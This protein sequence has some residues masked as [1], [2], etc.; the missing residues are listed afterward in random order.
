MPVLLKAINSVGD[1]SIFGIRVLRA[2]FRRPVEIGQIV[3]HMYE[4]G[5]RSLPLVGAAG[6]AVGAVMSMHTRASLERFGA[7]AMIP[8]GL[9]AAL[10][11]ETGPLVTALLFS[12]RVGAGIGAELGAMRVS[13]QID[14]LETLAVDSFKYLVVTR[15]LACIAVMPLL[16]VAANFA[17]IFGGYVAETLISGMSYRLYWERAFS[18]IGFTDYIPATM[19]TAVFGFIIGTTSAY[20]GYNTAGGAAG[21]GQAATRSVVFSSLLVIL[22]N[23]ILVK[24]IFVLFAGVS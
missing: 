1:A 4:F 13:E 11:K 19:K 5:A 18:L 3:R 14:A 7:E 24:A 10:V 21:V 20:L 22:S 16:V 17:G 6:V 8:A 2:S 9:G 12:G 15:V 23:V